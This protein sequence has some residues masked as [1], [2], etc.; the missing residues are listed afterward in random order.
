MWP[1]TIL[2]DALELKYPLIQAGM[3]G[4][5]TT[6]ELV[7]AVSN[8]GGLGTLGAGYLSP[9][10]IRDAIRKTRSLSNQAFAVN[11][12]VPDTESA[13]AAEVS[14]MTD[15]LHR[16]RRLL[17]FGES[18]IPRAYA[19]SF[20]NQLEVLVEERV[21]AFSF[22]FGVPMRQQISR[23]KARKILVMGTATTVREAMVLESYGVDVIVA[24]GSEAGGH[25]GTFLDEPVAGM[26]GTMAL[27]PQIV[28]RVNVQWSQRVESW[29]GEVCWQASHWGLPESKWDPSFFRAS[30]A[31]RITS[32][33]KRL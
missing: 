28:D 14:A 26:I 20:E 29:M 12:F 30:R 17:D 22:T 27:V 13:S 25:R 31:E 1:R 11:L 24:Q 5:V 4:G 8:A 6:P 10:Q 33:K 7:G 23:L 18:T 16:Y 21:P 15:Y 3:A 2:T 19:E 9:E 32:I